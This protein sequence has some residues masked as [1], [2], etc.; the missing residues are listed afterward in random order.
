MIKKLTTNK[1]KEQELLNLVFKKKN[2]KILPGKI[3]DTIGIG[4]KGGQWGFITFYSDYDY[5]MQSG[6]ASALG[7]LVK[8]GIVKYEQVKNGNFYYWRVK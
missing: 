8:K 6:Y 7:R 4:P 3:Y 2:K 1:T 5:W